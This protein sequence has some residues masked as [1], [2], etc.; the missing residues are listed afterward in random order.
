MANLI[1]SNRLPQLPQSNPK[2]GSRANGIKFTPKPQYSIEYWGFGVNS[3]GG[4][5]RLFTLPG[6][7]L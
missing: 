7:E 2:W 5:L 4:F 1:P 3:W 6:G